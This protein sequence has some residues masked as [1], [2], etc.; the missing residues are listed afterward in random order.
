MVKVNTLVNELQ[1][2]REEG[3]LSDALC[4]HAVRGISLFNDRFDW[5][6]VYILN[7]EEKVLWLHNYVGK[8]TSHVRIPVGNGVC[9]TAVAQ[10]ENI[11]VPDVSVLD[12][13][14]S[15]DPKVKSEMV[16]LIQSEG[17]IFGQIDIDSRTAAAFTDD[18]N[19]A[20]QA[21]ADELA[22]QFNT[23]HICRDL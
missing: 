1:N 23:E 15:C 18:D 17:T 7:S 6:G 10:A 8:S 11:N 14:L 19:L 2:L 20:V 5:V 21:V 16:I 22:E 4:R 13:Y 3:F 9:G 12:N